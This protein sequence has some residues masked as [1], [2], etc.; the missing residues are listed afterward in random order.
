MGNPAS[1]SPQIAA[2]QPNTGSSLLK[3]ENKALKSELESLKLKS[4][5]MKKTRHFELD[6]IHFNDVYNLRSQFKEEP[7]G[8]VTK[9][10]T[11]LF[12]L[13]AELQKLGREPLIVFSGDFVGPSLL[14]TIT[15]GA[16]LI[17]AF[18]ELGVQYGTFGNVVASC[19]CMRLL[20]YITNHR[21]PRV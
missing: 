20:K 12:N 7:V 15:Q 13:K 19:D 6:I 2:E 21:K 17:E 14:S 8:G 5:S 16:H 1:K 18:N 11:V 3:E 9:F 4:A 10:A